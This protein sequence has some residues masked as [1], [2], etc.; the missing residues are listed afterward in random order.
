[1]SSEHIGHEALYTRIRASIDATP[2]AKMRTSS[3]VV[4]A[5]AAVI[6]LSTAI[7]FV[8]SEIVYGRQ[9]LGLQVNVLSASRLV[10]VTCLLLA[11]TFM[12][13]AIALWRGGSGLGAGSS[14]LAL[15]AV[16][17]AP[18][19]ALFVLPQPVH[20]Q[21]A[22]VASVEIS[23]WGVRC[24]AIATLTGLIV[25]TSLAA[26]LRRAVPVASRLRG[27]V[28]GA[29]AGAWAGLAV[30]VFCPSGDHLHITLGHVLPVVAFTALGGLIVS[31]ALRP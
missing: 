6:V 24:F 20:L 8:S 3:R 17:V 15:V 26:A 28:L 19:Y 31:R 29:A 22:Y 16:L 4:A 23:P 30:F 14:T 18:L 11:L 25:L 21:N 5:L 12:S 13:T 7:V 2:A 27:A 1:M 9:A 10:W